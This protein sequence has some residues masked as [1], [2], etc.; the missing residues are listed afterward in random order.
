[1]GVQTCALPISIRPAM[2]SSM[3]QAMYSWCQLTENL[4]PIRGRK[5]RRVKNKCSFSH[6]SCSICISSK[7]VFTFEFIHHLPYQFFRVSYI[8]CIFI[9][10]WTAVWASYFLLGCA[11]ICFLISQ[12]QHILFGYFI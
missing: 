7:L 5:K 3:A 1:T 6:R 8:G 2:T 12:F 10:Q 4:K 9:L 11:C